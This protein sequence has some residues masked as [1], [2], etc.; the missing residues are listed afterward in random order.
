MLINL[1]FFKMYMFIPLVSVK[2]DW[3]QLQNQPKIKM[4]MNRARSNLISLLLNLLRGVST[5]NSIDKFRNYA[6]CKTV[7]HAYCQ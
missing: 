2:K 3:Y 6:N 7:D 5:S 4:I 1:K